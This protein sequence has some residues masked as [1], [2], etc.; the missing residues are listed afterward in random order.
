[1]L[2]KWQEMQAKKRRS[3]FNFHVVFSSELSEK[4]IIRV[5]MQKEFIWAAIQ[6]QGFILIWIV[7]LSV[8]SADTIAI[9]LSL[10]AL[11]S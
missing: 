11:I 4:K 6:R 10:S 7:I 5:H 2:F 9:D 8:Y 1:V 3:A